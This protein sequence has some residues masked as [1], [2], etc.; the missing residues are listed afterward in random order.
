MEVLKS[1]LSSLSRH[2]VWSSYRFSHLACLR[3]PLLDKCAAGFSPG[4][5]H[6]STTPTCLNDVAVIVAICR[7]RGVRNSMVSRRHAVLSRIVT[8][9]GLGFRCGEATAKLPQSKVWHMGAREMGRKLRS[10]HLKIDGY[11]SLKVSVVNGMGEKTPTI[12]LRT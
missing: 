12:L 8:L 7:S 5:A 1:S 10:R 6:A 3:Y 11:I 9:L 4:A 2:T